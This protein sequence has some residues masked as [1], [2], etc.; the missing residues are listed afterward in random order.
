MCHMPFKRLVGILTR[1]SQLGEIHKDSALL[2]L[3]MVLDKV[4]CFL[5]YFSQF[6]LTSYTFRTETT[7]H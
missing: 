1:S 6:M 2:M 7:R 4:V 5:P 3:R